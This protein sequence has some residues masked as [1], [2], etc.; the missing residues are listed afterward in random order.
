MKSGKRRRSKRAE[1]TPQPVEAPVAE[2]VEEGHEPS[3]EV[4]NVSSS[5]PALGELIPE[6]KRFDRLL[7]RSVAAAQA[8]YGARAAADPFRGLHISQSEVEQLLAR[9]PGA[10]TLQASD[11]GLEETLPKAVTEDSRLRWLEETFGLAPFEVDVILLALAPEL[12]LR[13]ERLYAYLQDNVTR[14]RPSVDLALNL[15]SP[16][17]EARLT[18]HTHFASE[19]P[20]I[21]HNLIHLHAD[22]QHIQ[23]PLLSHYLKLDDQIVRLLLRQESLDSRLAPFCEMVGPAV[24][25]DELPLSADMKRALPGLMVQA[26]E[27]RQ[28]LR[29]YFQGPHGTGKRRAAEALAGAVGRPLLVMDLARALAANMEFDQLVKV[30]FREAWL[31]DAIVY[32]DGLDALRGDDRIIPYQRLLD[33]LGEYAAITILAG[34]RPWV[35]TGRSPL[36]VITVPF[37][38]PDFALRRACWQAHLSSWD[39]TLDGNE[40]NTLADRFRLTPD[41]IAEAVATAR[42]QALLR[43]AANSPGAEAFEYVPSP[44]MAEISTHPSFRQ[45]LPESSGRDATRFTVPSA[46][47]PPIHGGSDDADHELAG[48][49]DTYALMRER[50]KDIPSPLIGEGEGG[51]DN[52]E[53]PCLQP[54]LNDFFIATRAQTG[55]DLAALTKKIAPKYTWEDIVLPEDALAQLREICQRVAYRHRVLDEWGFDRKLSLGKGIN[56]LFSGPSGTGKTMAAEVIANALGLDLYKIDLSAVVSKYIGETEKNLERIF[57]AAESANAILFFDEA[58]ALFGKRSEVRDAHDRY[59]NIEIAYL[60]QKMEQY[61][62]LAIL[63]TNLRQNMDEAFIRRLQCIVGFPFPDEAHRYQI[64]QVHFPAEAPRDEHVDLGFL[65]KQFRL[66]GGNIKN[67]V[68][69]AAF[70]SAANGGEIDMA[71]LIRATKRE[72]Q[73]MGRVPSESEFGKYTGVLQ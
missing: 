71:H 70:L 31:Q 69:H 11:K 14:R 47:S 54:T 45:G 42:N 35:P 62:G 33:A 38:I 22:P 50:S 57:T 60:L 43:T 65:A 23:P 44:S 41:Q 9:E 5:G 29:L 16:S 30:L 7:E 3:I 63:A 8:V 66:A 25:V 20:L 1:S 24:S 28:P 73:K 18:N 19:A 27:A 49:V 6:L 21:R 15:L 36:G 67:I 39:I 68:L 48:S 10:P 72:Y 46:G 32:L 26:K 34:T 4:P 55:H 13:Y 58:D 64:W 40:V 37:S 61:D 53:T 56:A 52:S 12:D 17:A 51:S 59:A 2:P